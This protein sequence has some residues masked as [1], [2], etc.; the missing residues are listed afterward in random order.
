MNANS[1]ANG[2]TEATISPARTLPEKNNQYQK[3]DD[4]TFYQIID[5][6]RNVTVHRIQNGSDKARW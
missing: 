2:M 4:R 3:Y 5:N 6:S 1:M